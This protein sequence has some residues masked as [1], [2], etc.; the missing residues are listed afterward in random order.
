MEEYTA[1]QIAEEIFITAQGQS[2]Y[3]N[4]L[5]VAK[6][7]PFLNDADRSVLDSYLTGT[8]ARSPFESRMKL[9]DIV[10]KIRQHT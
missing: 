7:F 9:Q 1:K 5:Y 4:A 6:D 2:Y 8:Y 10:I 3:G